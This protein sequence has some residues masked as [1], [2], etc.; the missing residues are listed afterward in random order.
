[1]LSQP[2]D[3]WVT[4]ASK[5][6][7]TTPAMCKCTVRCLL[8]ACARALVPARAPVRLCKR[9]RPCGCAGACAR[10]L[11]QARAPV[12]LCRRVRRC[13]CAGGCRGGRVCGG[14]G[15]WSGSVL[16]LSPWFSVHS[17]RC[18]WALAL[19]RSR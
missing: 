18:V 13:T 9:V 6:V 15:L 12:R 7:F 1:M 17:G 11:V 10:A 3:A 19:A 14:G 5:V 4:P 8:S 2:V 16:L